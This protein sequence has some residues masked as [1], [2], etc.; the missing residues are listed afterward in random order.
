MQPELPTSQ[1]LRVELVYLEDCP[2]LET[3]QRRLRAAL[4]ES[5]LPAVWASWNLE[6]WLPDSLRG[7]PSPSILID[8]VNVLLEHAR[9]DGAAPACAVA[10]APPI[11]LIAA[12]LERALAERHRRPN[13]IEVT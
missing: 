8:G 1:P 3:A 6:R 2:H 11:H 4:S 7:L 5:G 12:A 9:H 10:G 13:P